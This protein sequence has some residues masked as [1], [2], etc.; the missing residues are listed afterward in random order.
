M[1]QGLSH[2]VASFRKASASMLLQIIKVHYVLMH[3]WCLVPNFF[4]PVRVCAAGLC[5]WSRPFLYMYIY[6]YVNK[7]TGCLVPYRSKISY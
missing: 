6:T 5:I 3:Q 7:K 4:Y 2:F 1:T